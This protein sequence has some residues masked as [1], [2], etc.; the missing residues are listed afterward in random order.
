MKL[1][2]YPPFSAPFS[3]Q[4]EDLLTG[5]DL[6]LYRKGV[7]A[8]AQG[9]GIG[10]ASYFRRIVEDQ[11]ELLVTKIRDAAQKLGKDDLSEFEAALQTHQFK[12]A[13]N[14]LKDAIP[15]KLLILNGLNP[16]TLL[17]KTLSEQLHGLTDEDFLQQAQ[18][19][20]VVL[21]ALLENITNVL[22]DED[23]LRA[24]ANRLT[25]RRDSS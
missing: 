8:I 4:I 7:Q 22:K 21:S 25:Q 6:E 15:D 24:A 18:D 17:H 2:E 1:G 20:R 3:R 10:A 9:L 13:V 5:E 14:L 11:W 19:I 16:L 23:E 12:K